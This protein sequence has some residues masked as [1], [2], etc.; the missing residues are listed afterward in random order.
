VN[1]EQ[2]TLNSERRTLADS[3]EISEFVRSFK[4][5]KVK[6]TIDINHSNI[7]ENILEVCRNCRDLIANIHVSDNHGEYEDHLVP[8]EG[9]IPIKAVMNELQACGYTGPC[10]LEFHASQLPDRNFILM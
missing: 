6:I 9:I 7:H 5:D 1:V 4:N 10:N 3:N 2:R 8:G